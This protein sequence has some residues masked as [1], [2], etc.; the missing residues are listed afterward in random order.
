MSN[1]VNKA[2][3]LLEKAEDYPRWT[4]YTIGFLRQKNCAWAI[5]A[6]TPITLESIREGCLDAEFTANQLTGA[7]LIKVLTDKRDK[8]R[9]QLTRARGIIKN[10]VAKRHFYLIADKESHEMLAILKPRF[11]D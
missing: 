9:E 10:Q 5:N 7:L 4:Q 6:P 11:Q 1:Q 8:Q 2:A 3:N